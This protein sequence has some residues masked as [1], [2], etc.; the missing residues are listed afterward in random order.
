VDETTERVDERLARANEWTELATFG[1]DGSKLVDAER[2]LDALAADVALARGRIL[3]ARFLSRRFGPQAEPDPAGDPRELELFEEALELFERVGDRRGQGEA[4]F[5]VGIF[6]QVVLG[7]GDTGVPFFARSAEAAAEA[8]DQM[9]VSYALRHLGFAELE[10]GRLDAAW[11]QFAESTRL[12]REAGFLP[13][14]AA[15]LVGMAEIA[16]AR[17]DRDEALRLIAEAIEVATG[18]G[19]ANVVMM[20]EQA[21][22]ELGEG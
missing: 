19:A 7:D 8:G 21:K 4:L 12:R 20:A 11:D 3:H 14:V 17:G 1:G 9:T 13:G 15:N 10:A 22:A 6:H 5:L 2:E 16:A 18:C